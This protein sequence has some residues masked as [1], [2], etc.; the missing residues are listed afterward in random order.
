MALVA[1]FHLTDSQVW[2]QPV[3]FFRLQ[4]LQ[5]EAVASSVFDVRPQSTADQNRTNNSLTDTE[6]D[7][8]DSKEMCQGV[9]VVLTFLVILYCTFG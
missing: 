9:L 7:F 3:K 8:Y 2:M 5:Q 1:L 6:P 4:V